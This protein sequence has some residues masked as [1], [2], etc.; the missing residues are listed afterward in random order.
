[1][2]IYK[3]NQI[4]KTY[5]GFSGNYAKKVACY[6]PVIY[7]LFSDL[8]DVGDGKEEAQIKWG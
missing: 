6:L 8:L 2:L 1:L 5:G 3:N 4:K 7:D